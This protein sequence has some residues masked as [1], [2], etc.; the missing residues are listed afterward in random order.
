MFYAILEEKARVVFVDEGSV[1]FS[2][3]KSL[4]IAVGKCFILGH[5]ENY[6]RVLSVKDRIVLSGCGYHSEQY[7]GRTVVW[8]VWSNNWPH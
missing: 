5:T 4:L 6:T 8:N 3:L 7:Q 1:F 2:S